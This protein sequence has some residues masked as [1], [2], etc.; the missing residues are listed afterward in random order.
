MTRRAALGAWTPERADPPVP[1]RGPETL[2]V[3]SAA[4]PAAKAAGVGGECGIAAGRGAQ[5]GN[6]EG[7]DARRHLP[8]LEPTNVGG[9]REGCS[10]D[11]TTPPHA[12]ALA[13]RG[14]WA[15]ASCA[16]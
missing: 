10:M 16:S 5:A 12:R 14:V 4:R 15:A 7:G 6:L 9:R 8:R 3:M 2:H 1:V 11:D 13:K